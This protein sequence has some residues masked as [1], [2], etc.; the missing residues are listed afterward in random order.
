MLRT[1]VLEPRQ[2]LAVTHSKLLL[3]EIPYERLVEVESKYPELG[4]ELK[5]PNMVRTHLLKHLPAFE[6]PQNAAE[7]FQIRHEVSLSALVSAKWGEEK[8][9]ALILEF[10][11]PREPLGCCGSSGFRGISMDLKVFSNGFQ[12]F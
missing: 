11:K 8:K 7:G 10:Q 4:F 6:R 5:M 3:A 9:P 2:V 12:R 1:K